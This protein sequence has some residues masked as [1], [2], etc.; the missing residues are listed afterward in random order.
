VGGAYSFFAATKN[1]QNF[2]KSVITTECIPAENPKRSM[3]TF[4]E[5]KKR[6]IIG[7]K[8]E[9][10]GDQAKFKHT[11]LNAATQQC[12]VLVMTYTRFVSHDSH[13][14]TRADKQ[15]SK[16]YH[17]LFEQTLPSHCNIW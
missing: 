11:V 13:V 15:R 6:F 14:A 2:K 3:K 7:V 4:E 16:E 5:T 12:S 1:R 8:I 10:N 17:L 9:R